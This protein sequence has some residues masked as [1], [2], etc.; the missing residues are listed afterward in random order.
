MNA[1]PTACGMHV[2]LMSATQAA[3]SFTHL[4]QSY[5]AWQLEGLREARDACGIAEAAK[6]DRFEERMRRVGGWLIQRAAS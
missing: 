1:I 3:R 5:C 6:R 2:P 4:G